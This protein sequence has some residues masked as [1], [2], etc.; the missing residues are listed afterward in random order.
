MSR[1]LGLLVFR[2]ERGICGG[3]SGERLAG[4]GRNDVTPQNTN[5]VVQLLTAELHL[6]PLGCRGKGARSL[7]NH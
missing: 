5:G 4:G 2:V 3:V 6:R 1:S 7:F